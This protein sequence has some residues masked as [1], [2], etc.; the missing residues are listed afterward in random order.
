MEFSV[1]EKVKKNTKL[2][3]TNMKKTELC[4]GQIRIRIETSEFERRRFSFSLL[5]LT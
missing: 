5:R 2:F 3:Q 4:Y 1:K